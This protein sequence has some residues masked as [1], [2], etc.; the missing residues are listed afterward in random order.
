MS[1]DEFIQIYDI[2]YENDE[3]YDIDK[4]LSR[5]DS[6]GELTIPEILDM[7]TDDAKE[8]LFGSAQAKYDK[9]QGTLNVGQEGYAEQL[10]NDA[11]NGNLDASKDFALGVIEMYEA[12]KAEGLI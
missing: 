6:E 11:V 7:M 9:I 8:S 5:Y 1:T 3:T 4:I 12:L 2:L 10:Y